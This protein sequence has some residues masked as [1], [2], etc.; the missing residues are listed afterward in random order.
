MRDDRRQWLLDRRALRRAA[1]RPFVRWS[2]RWDRVVWRGEGGSIEATHGSIPRGLIAIS[3]QYLLLH[4]NEPT[5]LRLIPNRL[6]PAALR[7]LSPI[8]EALP[9]GSDDGG[10]E[11]DCCI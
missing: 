6:K 3:A 7:R 9:P 8:E 10:P 1:A 4:N 2:A 5:H 11:Y